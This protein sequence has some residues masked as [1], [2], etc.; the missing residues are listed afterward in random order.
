[1]HSLTYNH[2]S[3]SSD[4]FKFS[5]FPITIPVWNRLPATEAEASSLVS[6]KRELATLHL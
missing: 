2:Y 4:V 1:M 3:T 5:F 6:F